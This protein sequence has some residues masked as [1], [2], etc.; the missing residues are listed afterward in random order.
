M[1]KELQELQPQLIN[2]SRETEELIIIIE[3]ETEEVEAV[4]KVVEADEA[5]ANKA[6][7]EAKSIKV[8]IFV[9][10]F[11]CVWIGFKELMVLSTKIGILYSAILS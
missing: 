11:V 6:A 8:Y 4:K 3:R 2:T 5:T 9:C 10:V 7:S 1:Q